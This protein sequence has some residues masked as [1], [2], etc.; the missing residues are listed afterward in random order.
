M[1]IVGNLKKNEKGL[2]AVTANIERCSR[3]LVEWKS[4]MIHIVKV[5]LYGRIH[6][7]FVR[8]AGKRKQRETWAG[9]S[10]H[11]LCFC[12]FFTFYVETIMYYQEVAKKKKEIVKRGS[13][14][15]SHRLPPVAVLCNS[16][17]IIQTR[18][19][20]W[21]DTIARL[22]IRSYLFSIVWLK[23]FNITFSSFST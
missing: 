7:K 8:R 13:P 20:H 17:C 3:Y 1:E 12:I 23:V 16:S 2:R 19:P 4:A 22:L 11:F 18:K 21:H 9:W 14:Y 5:Y 6:K 15:P 10:F